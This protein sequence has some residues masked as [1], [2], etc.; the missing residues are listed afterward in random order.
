MLYNPTDVNGNNNTDEQ[1]N[2][3]LKGKKNIT[4]EEV[5]P[6]VL[7]KVEHQICQFVTYNAE[8]TKS[9]LNFQTIKENTQCIFAKRSRLWGSPEWKEDL[10]LEENV[11]RS[12]PTFL[13]FLSLCPV[14]GLDGF[15]YE[16]PRN[17][18]GRDVDTFAEVVRRVL[19]V[20]SDN[21]P[22]G[23][24]CMDRSYIGK[25]GWVFEF[26]KVTM[27]VTTFAPF[28]PVTSPRFAF[29][30]KNTYILFQ[31]EVSFAQYDLGR[32]TP[33]TNWDKPKTVRD[34]IR[35]NFRDAGRPYKIR[36]SIYY[37]VAHDIVKPLNEFE[38][39]VVEFWMDEP[40]FPSSSDSEDF[41]G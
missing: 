7:H 6:E 1:N 41:E 29:G 11:L 8:N 2:N 22:A 13:K 21:D 20:L 26:N 27:F 34:Q 17:P 23:L 14:M 12:I 18:Y 25:K 15:V 24:H 3:P 33:H 5:P 19:T 40:T 31:P 4:E 16:L 35:V 38:G 37:P 36:E 32:D 39:A 30:A 9:L 10:C 28:Y